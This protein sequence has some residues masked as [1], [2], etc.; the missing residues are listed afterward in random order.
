VVRTRSEHIT[1]FSIL[2]DM[3]HSSF[4]HDLLK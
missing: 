2:N 1:S 4:G 3:V